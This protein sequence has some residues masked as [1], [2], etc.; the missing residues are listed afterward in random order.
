METK[1]V[2]MGTPDFALPTLRALAEKFDVA[3]AVTQ[4][5]RRAG[6]G[7]EFRPPPVKVLAEELGIPVFQPQ[8]INTPDALEQLS[9]WAPE[10][11]A[12]AAFGQI[13]SPEVLD[14]PPQ[15]CLNVHASLL[16]R[17]R[18]AS[19]IN[20]A[21]LHGD[22]ETGVTIMKMGQGLDSGPILSQRAVPIRAED[23][24]GSL[25][26]TLAQLGA[27]L[28]VETIP[29]YLMGALNPCSQGDKGATYAPL[30]N[31]EDGELGFNQSAEFLARKIR[32][33][34]PWP[35]TYTF[36]KDQRFKILKAHAVPVTS[37][38]VGVFTTYEKSPAIGTNDEVLVLDQVQPAGKCVMDGVSFLCGAREWEEEI[39]KLGG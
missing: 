16:P 12:V 39:R 30:L 25:F 8:D 29:L 4:P 10:L 31:R 7:R 27:D 24:A 11:I 20:A 15:G 23:T 9:V 1:I 17:W 6:R 36:W 38:G 37:P 3:G 35:G 2:F 28:L 13:L 34:H 26:D 14:L 5:D 18:G 21:I 33:F 32:A 22:E 19:P